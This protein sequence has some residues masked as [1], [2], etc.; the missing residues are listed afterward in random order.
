MSTDMPP[1]QRADWHGVVPAITTPHG[2]GGIID[3]AFFRRHCER[4]VEHGCTAIVT[5]GSLGAGG[6]LSLNE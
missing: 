3:T 5:P 1:M 6:L 4:M 2:D